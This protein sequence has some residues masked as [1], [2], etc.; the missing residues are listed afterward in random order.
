M[1]RRLL[2]VTYEPVLKSTWTSLGLGV[3]DALA[4]V[5]LGFPESFGHFYAF[6]EGYQCMFRML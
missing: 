5:H 1:G 4:N 6:L 2:G 3:P